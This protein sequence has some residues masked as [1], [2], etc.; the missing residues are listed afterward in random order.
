MAP[1][2]VEFLE[3]AD[4]VFTTQVLTTSGATAAGDTLVIAYG[5]DF[6]TFA[7][8][9]NVTSSAGTPALVASM[10]MGDNIGHA[11]VFTCAVASGGA[12]TVT[13]PAHTDCD[14][15]GVVM[16][17]PG[18]VT[19]DGTP[20]S[21][22]VATNTTAA[23]VAPSMTTTDIDRLLVCVWLT[24]SGPGFVGEPYVL[25]GGMTKRGETGASP[26]SDMCVGTESIAAAGAT[27]TRTATWVDTKRYGSISLALA[28]AGGGGATAAPPSRG[29]RLGALLQL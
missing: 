17:F 23:H 25:P 5:S 11:K 19:L 3:T 7:S 18:A 21:Q 8:M 27:G 12:K 4:S 13:I 6:Y 2:P 16:R 14:I 9:P 29:R 22:F 1:T 26:F 28:G 20:T 15:H 24:T 10:T